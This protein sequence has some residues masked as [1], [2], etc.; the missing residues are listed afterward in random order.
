[1]HDHTY[2]TTEYQQ[3]LS[4]HA[5]LEVDTIGQLV[6][7]AQLP[8]L[9]GP[10]GADSMWS[11][12]EDD[13]TRHQGEAVAHYLN[14]VAYG[15]HHLLQGAALALLT[16]YRECK[17]CLPKGREGL[18]INPRPHHCRVWECLHHEEGLPAL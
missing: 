1:M 16:I 12:C 3:C 11:A 5:S 18:D 6:T 10:Q 8:C 2:V 17:L 14:G 4:M 7:P 15:V 9:A 13:I